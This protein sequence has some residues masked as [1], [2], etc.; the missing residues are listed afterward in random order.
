MKFS[1][2][3]RRQAV[4]RGVAALIKSLLLVA[5]VPIAALR[6]WLF[7]SQQHYSFHIG[8]VVEIILVAVAIFWLAAVGQLV[9]E[10]I[11]AI[12]TPDERMHSSWSS[13]WASGIVGLLLLAG[14]L[15]AHG[16]PIRPATP[17]AHISHNGPPRIADYA[18]IDVNERIAIEVVAGLGA[19]I[20]GGLLRRTQLLGRLRIGIR[21]QGGMLDTP[22]DDLR[23]LLRTLHASGDERLID[24]VEAAN[25]LLGKCF[26]GL[27]GPDL[28]D[29][30]LLRVGSGR[31]E[32]LLNSPVPDS[33]AQFI[34]SH[35]G[36]WWRI[37]PQLSL[38]EL[39]KLGSGSARFIPS[40][41]PVGTDGTAEILVAMTPSRVFGVLGSNTA[42][43]ATI[44]ACVVALRV[45]PWCDEIA[46][47]LIGMQAPPLEEQCAHIQQSSLET[48]EMLSDRVPMSRQFVAESW[49]REPLVVVHRSALETTS[50]DRLIDATTRF[51]AVVGG[52]HGDVTL[53]IEGQRATLEPYNIEIER[54]STR[55]EQRSV[56]DRLLSTY[57]QPADVVDIREHSDRTRQI[58]IDPDHEDAE[59]QTSDIELRILGDRVEIIGAHHRAHRDDADRVHELLVFLALH[60]FR[61]TPAQLLRELF[62]NGSD[63]AARVRLEN[64]VAI[65]RTVLGRTQRG[66]DRVRFGDDGSVTLDRSIVLDWHRVAHDIINAQHV[67]G[68]NAIEQLR[69]TLLTLDE[70]NLLAEASTYPWF[71]AM[72]YDEYIKATIIDACHHL[73]T[74]AQAGGDYA[75]ARRALELGY[76]IEPASEIIARDH[77]VFAE[78]TGDTREVERIYKELQQALHGLGGAEP[79]AVTHRLYLS[80]VRAGP[81][82]Y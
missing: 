72:R 31:V 38:I 8:L 34:T 33:P 46:V 50:R 24:W 47:E 30:A 29:I 20:C 63:T 18:T 68:G 70:Q 45:L 5:G 17:I 1:R 60:D 10:I 73:A 77:M 16:S 81:V 39:R 15:G 43:D 58:P 79:S 48:L 64:V 69:S 54:H 74:L 61:A 66:L 3:N 35:G 44:D 80:L 11:R 57:A 2:G 28:P 4:A 36:L 42:V 23:P 19:L 7:S 67:D 56:I 55:V 51:A 76:S 12:R 52:F 75:L 22:P 49:R 13:S 25:R 53:T 37:D 40:L 26:A 71:R 59:L 32:I 6:L 82:G 14:A 9:G 21:D 78:S 62:V 65:A 27:D 41:I